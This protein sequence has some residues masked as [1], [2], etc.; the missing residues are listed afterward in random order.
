MT[1][2][3]FTN[4]QWTTWHCFC[5]DT[6]HYKDNHLSQAMPCRW[7][8]FLSVWII[9]LSEYQIIWNIYWKLCSYSYSNSSFVFGVH[10]WHCFQRY[11]R[12]HNLRKKDSLYLAQ[13]LEFI[14]AKHRTSKSISIILYFVWKCFCNCIWTLAIN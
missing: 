2:S 9:I 8:C 11:C 7:P 6:G 13:H 14:L 1:E 4:T 3:P 12:L 10:L 5:K